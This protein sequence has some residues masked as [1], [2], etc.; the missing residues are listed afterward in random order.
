M[1]KLLKMMKRSGIVLLIIAA[2][3][4]VLQTYFDLQVPAY[5]QRILTI[6]QNEGASDAVNKRLMYG[7]LPSIILILVGSL[8]HPQFLGDLI[9][10][11]QHPQKC[12]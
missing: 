11:R 2:A 12:V 10:H 8:G 6:A 9:L 4:I 1:F 5:M 3:F 7:S